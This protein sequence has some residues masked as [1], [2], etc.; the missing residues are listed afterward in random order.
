MNKIPQPLNKFSSLLAFLEVEGK[1]ER[2]ALN[3]RLETKDLDGK[4]IPCTTPQK[5]HQINAPLD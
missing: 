4:S 5:F 1:K 2:E 3:K